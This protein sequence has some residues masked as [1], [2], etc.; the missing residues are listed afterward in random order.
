MR[1]VKT[2]LKIIS[3]TNGLLCTDR[4]HCSS[5][6]GTKYR[7]DV[8]VFLSRVDWLILLLL[9]DVMLLLLVVLL[10]T[11]PLSLVV[12]YMRDRE[13]TRGLWVSFWHWHTHTHHPLLFTSQLSICDIKGITINSQ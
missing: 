3:A 8:K 2:N 11:T 5:T 10:V 1:R 12:C 13:S 9:H 7:F 6:T 4:I